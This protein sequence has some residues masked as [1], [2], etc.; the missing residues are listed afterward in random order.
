MSPR[1]R[2][3]LSRRRSR[4]RR[5]R[6]AL[7]Y[8]REAQKPPWV[9]LLGRYRLATWLVILVV[10]VAVVL[11]GVAAFFVERAAVAGRNGEQA[12]LQAVSAVEHGPS[13]GITSSQIEAAT[14]RVAAATGDFDAMRRDLNRGGPALT[15]ARYIPFIRVQVRAADTLADTGQELAASAKA[16]VDTAGQFV[17]PANPNQ[18]LSD[19][20]KELQ[21]LHSAAATALSALDSAAAQ[22]A[23]LND[24]RLVGPLNSARAALDQHLPH[25]LARATDAE[26]AL[27]AFIVFAGGA[28]PR[29]YLLLS[30]NP[31]EV[32]PTGGFIGT[33][34]VMSANNGHLS[35]DRYDAIE[36]WY[37]PRPK[38]VVPENQAPPIF[39]IVGSDQNLA[40]INAEPDWPTD[41][42]VAEELWQQG[43]EAPVDGVLSMT[44]AFLARV[45]GVLG[46][47][48]VPA[49]GET[50]TGANLIQRVNFWT[51]S[52]AVL[53][54]PGGRKEFVAALSQVVFQRLLAAPASQWEPLAAAGAAGFDAGEAMLSAD[55]PDVAGPAANHGWDGGFPP[56]GSNGD[57]Y[58]DS[59]FETT[60]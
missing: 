53:P 11:I 48:S 32:R 6:S 25:L 33:Y 59:E 18:P 42:Q 17:R 41:A 44:P 8:R 57:F 16:L 15:V 43:G 23:S 10:A 26:Q 34:G 47:V 30:Q 27:R 1:G 29:R 55:D 49:Y 20:V 5:G 22:V 54:Q 45:V 56:K 14:S 58:F 60:A 37:R 9:R 39:Q 13:T 35:L 31:D 52:E 46:P 19:P 40:N 36:N 28:G 50:V 38:A 2:S 4:Q 12:L 7:A 3:A 24:D 21:P 51:H